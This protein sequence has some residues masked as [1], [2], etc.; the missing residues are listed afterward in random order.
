[1]DMDLRAGAR[2]TGDIG[3]I[4]FAEIELDAFVDIGKS[5]AGGDGRGFGC[6]LPRVKPNAVV[7]DVQVHTILAAP[8]RDLK[9][10]VCGLWL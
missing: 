4:V 2:N 3:P 9:Q 1:M 5:D 7:T 8:A 6:G 10:A